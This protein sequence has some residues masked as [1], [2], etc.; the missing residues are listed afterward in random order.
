[1]RVLGL[2]MIL[3]CAAARGQDGQGAP[4]FE[5]ATVRRVTNGW[6]PGGGYRPVMQGGPGTNDPG[7]LHWNSVPMNTLILEAYGINAYEFSGPDWLGSELY[8]I[9]A[10]VPAGATHEQFQVMLQNLLKERFHMVVHH[11]ERLVPGYELGIAKDGPKLKQAAAEGSEP[12]PEV[13]HHPDKDGFAYLSP[14]HPNIVTIAGNGGLR[15]SAR[16][17][18]AKDFVGY[19]AKLLGRPV[20][21]KTG[22]T[23]RYDIRLGFSSAGLAIARATDA[24]LGEDDLFKAL[25]VQL[26]LT[27][28]SKREPVDMRVIDSLEKTPTEN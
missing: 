4:A 13:Q 14:G 11:E 28:D 9:E 17:Q 22:L 6:L 16:S 24:D 20:V 1:M 15:L 18:T 10:K 21:D 8:A 5:V 19:I 3:S 27:L 2:V 23:G 25:R 26:G 7:R 12:L